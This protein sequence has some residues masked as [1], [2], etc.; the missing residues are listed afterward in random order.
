MRRITLAL[1]AALL[2]A[3][4]ALAELK[5]VATLTDLGR[6]VEAV[7]GDHVSVDVLC[8]GSRDPHSLPAK[9][10]LARKLARADLLCYNGLEL[11]IGWLPQLIDKARNPRVR[12][13]AGGDLD[14]SAAVM[15]PLELHHH[16][17]DRGEGDVHPL[18]NPHYT[19]DPRVTSEV[20]RL[21]ADRLGRLDPERA[22][23]YLARAD[24]FAARLEARRLDWI[25][26]TAAVRDHPVIVYHRNWSYLADWLELDVVA[27]IEHRPGISPSPRHVSDV[28]RRGAL[29]EEPIV[30]AAT[31]D[32]HHVAEEVA[33]RIGAPLAVLPAYSGATEGAEDYVDFLDLICERLAA[34]AAAAEEGTP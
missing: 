25:E 26:R 33:E 12:P 6:V 14:C 28:I 16:P 4:P 5:V 2:A 21:V 22:E 31:W 29:L 32:H 1:L 34:A 23:E 7:G 17:V 20:A 27:E 19:L 8:P 11:E 3:A 13:G 9:P 15:H 30:V 24:A 10:S 18:G